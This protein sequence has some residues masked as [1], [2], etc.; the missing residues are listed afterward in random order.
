MFTMDPKLD[1]HDINLVGPK[2]LGF[3][4][5]CEEEKRVNFFSQQGQVGWK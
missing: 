1:G 3:F 2:H 4:F 5:Y